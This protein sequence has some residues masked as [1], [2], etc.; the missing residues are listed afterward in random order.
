MTN[1]YAVDYY[2]FLNN[3]YKD[4]LHN[5]ISFDLRFVKKFP[6]DPD[7][8]E[9]YKMDMAVLRSIGN[10]IKTFKKR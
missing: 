9:M 3:L 5:G 4:F 7:I 2:L 8:R 10:E 6:N 1:K